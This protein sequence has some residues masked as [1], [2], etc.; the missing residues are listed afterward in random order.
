MDWIVR[1][2]D[3]ISAFSHRHGTIERQLSLP[4]PTFLPILSNDSSSRAKMSAELTKPVKHDKR[5]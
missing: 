4:T 3:H 5:E 2:R 1:A